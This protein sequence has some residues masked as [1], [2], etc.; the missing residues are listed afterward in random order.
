MDWK[1]LA[2]KILYP[3]V[4]L[5]IVLTV[6]SAVGVPL[7]LIKLGSESPVSYVVYVVAFYTLSVVC[8]FLWRVLPKRYRAIKQRISA[9]PLGNRYLTDEVFRA[10]VSL[11]ASLV[12]NLLYV[13]INVLSYVLYRSM[14]FIVLAVYY[15]ILA[16]MRF[17]LSRYAGKKRTVKDLTAQLKSVRLCS[18]I[19]LTL[20]FCLSGAV[21]MILYQNKG[22]EYSGILIYVM[23]AYTFYIT[24]HAVWDL[25]KY[26]SHP[27]PVMTMSKVV[28]LSAALV[29]MLSLETAMFSQFGQDMAA[30]DKRLMIALTG[31][32]V[33]IVVVVMSVL[34][35]IKTTGE[36]KKSRGN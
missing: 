32:G 11:Y 9:H 24:V 36:I 17:L 27:S 33:S 30:G 29:S 34:M 2:N 14:W 10:D 3:P 19:L 12:I 13:G 22:F 7:A 5:M 1:K 23:A 20:N 35:I 28:A 16:V 4:W 15:S 21:L 26:R 31:A 18:F 25:I 6:F 8:I